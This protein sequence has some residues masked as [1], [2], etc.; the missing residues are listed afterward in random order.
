MPNRTLANATIVVPSPRPEL[1]TIVSGWTT[2]DIF[3]ESRD[4]RM[5]EVVRNRET[6]EIC[7]FEAC[8]Q[9]SVTY[10][11][12]VGHGVLSFNNYAQVDAKL[13]ELIDAGSVLEVRASAAPRYELHYFEHRTGMVSEYVIGEETLEYAVDF[14]IESHL[15]GVPLRERMRVVRRYLTAAEFTVLS[16]KQKES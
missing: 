11:T 1:E 14:S 3:S 12:S 15:P 6:G 7:A 4:P 9:N 13:R 10:W 8:E 16:V 5:V 2:G